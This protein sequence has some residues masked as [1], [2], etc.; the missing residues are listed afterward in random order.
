MTYCDASL[1]G[2]EAALDIAPMQPP[3]QGEA[4]PNL[5]AMILLILPGDE[6]GAPDEASGNTR[7]QKEGRLAQFHDMGGT[8]SW[9]QFPG[10]SL[11]AD[12]PVSFLSAGLVTEL[13]TAS[14]SMSR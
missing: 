3:C 13:A 8:T 9:A 10:D 4:K 12:P 1:E 11:R 14:C 6:R 7:E 5:H 2:H